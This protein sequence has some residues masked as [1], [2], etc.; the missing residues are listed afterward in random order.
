MKILLTGY[1]GQL[2][3]SII[4]SKPKNI[5]IICKNR[6][7]LDLLSR[8]S[9]LKIVKDNKPDWIINCAAYTNVDKAEKEK[10]LA[11]NLNSLTPKYLSE[12]VRDYGGDILHISTDYVFNGKKNIPY[13][14]N[15]KKSPISTYGY[16]K[17]KGEDFILKVLSDLNKGN[18]IRTSWL[19]SIYGNNFALKIIEKMKTTEKLKIIFDQLGSPTTASS[20]AH[21]CWKTIKLKSKNKTVPNIMHFTNSGVA[22]WYDVAISLAEIG[23]E[24][25]ILNKEINILPINSEEYPTA[26]IRPKYSV[27]NSFETFERLSLKPVYWKNAIKDLLLELKNLKIEKNLF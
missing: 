2:G 20:L 6:S 23:C 17:S 4:Y 1:S 14:P 21:A 10:D 3:K 12:A 5:N 7:Q 13:L 11:Y 8:D 19:M 25:N 22:S 26:A 9:C 27:L 16:T 24:L 15:D 18:I